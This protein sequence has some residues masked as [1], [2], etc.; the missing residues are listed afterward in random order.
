MHVCPHSVC[1]HTCKYEVHMY[2]QHTD[3]DRQMH[4]HR[5]THTQTQ[6]RHRQTERQTDREF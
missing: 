3:T 1:T 5:H 6:T 2:T 4:R